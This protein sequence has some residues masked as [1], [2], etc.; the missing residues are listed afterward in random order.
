[1]SLNEQNIIL[2]S[3]AQFPR[4]LLG[5][6]KILLLWF[7]DFDNEKDTLPFDF[8]L[9]V[10]SLEHLRVQ[11]CFGLTEIF[12]SQVRHGILAGLKQLF[13]YDLKE[14]E[15][16][17]LEQ[18]WVKPY[19]EKLEVLQLRLC[20][21]QEKLVCFAVSFINLKELVVSDCK[22]MEY[23]FTFSTAKSLVQLEILQID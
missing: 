7:E 5:K 2:L 18:P 14:L 21:R 23:L 12:P 20:S 13:L 17:G 1:M 19:S 8:I 11:R 22:M 10:P 16:I 4:D 15:L 6:L 9:K 3:D